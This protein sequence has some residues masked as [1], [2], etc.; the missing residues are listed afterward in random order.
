MGGVLLVVAK[1]MLQNQVRPEDRIIVFVNEKKHADF[2]GRIV[3]R[4][5]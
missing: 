4:G 5:Y 3:E 1:D 2:V